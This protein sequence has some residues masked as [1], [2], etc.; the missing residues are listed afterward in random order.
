VHQHVHQAPVTIA[1]HISWM[2]IQP[3]WVDEERAMKSSDLMMVVMRSLNCTMAWYHNHKYAY[4]FQCSVY[5]QISFGVEFRPDAVSINTTKSG[6]DHRNVLSKAT[7]LCILDIESVCDRVGQLYRYVRQQIPYTC[8][9]IE[10]SRSMSHMSCI[11]TSCAPSNM[12][13][14]V[15]GMLAGFLAITKTVTQPRR[16]GLESSA[17][18]IAVETCPP[19]NI[20][21]NTMCCA[22]SFRGDT[23][24]ITYPPGVSLSEG[25]FWSDRP[26]EISTV[27]W[28]FQNRR[29]QSDL[30][31]LVCTMLLQCQKCIYN[32]M[33]CERK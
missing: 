6:C 13:Q 23:F 17:Y 2:H 27:Y 9:D 24:N 29:P 1:V 16:V 30:D 4:V 21:F 8:S 11:P 25:P 10:P 18:T 26:P 15:A 31:V 14:L 32:Y 22:I 3:Y 12:V 20:I 33:K 28:H 5:G 19:L 7:V